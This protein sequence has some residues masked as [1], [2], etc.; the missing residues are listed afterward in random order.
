VASGLIA[1]DALDALR[2]EADAT[3]VTVLDVRGMAAYLKGHIPGAVSTRWQDFLDPDSKVKGILH[4][5]SAELARRFG[6]LGVTNDRPVVVY[7]EPFEYWGAEGRFFWMLHYLG[8]D[9]VRV[10]DGGF[11]KWRREGREVA[12]MPTRAAL[13]PFT[14]VVR[15]E[16]LVDRAGV[17]AA[18]EDAEAVI[19]DARSSEEYEKE[20]HVPGAVSL[21]WS[22]LYTGDGTVRPEPELRALLA[23]AGVTP[24]REIVPYCTGGVRS[25]W[26][27]TVLHLLGYPRLRNYDGSWWDWTHD[28][29]MPIER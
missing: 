3:G 29:R 18:V 8:H 28:G 10:L 14:P 27:F 17:E 13:R 1:T 24:D 16:T 22:A 5:D 23:A 26:L 15:L 9:D 21:P 6:A 11:P 20:G 25:A 7:S 2:G 19:V 4:P 12:H